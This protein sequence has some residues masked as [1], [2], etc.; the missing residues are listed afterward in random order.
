[1]MRTWLPGPKPWGGTTNR[2]LLKRIC[3]PAARGAEVLM[4]I[5]CWMAPVEEV[6]NCA[7][8]VAA[9]HADIGVLLGAVAREG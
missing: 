5:L 9:G 7:L 2:A 3:V 1:M 8:A 4:T 6:L